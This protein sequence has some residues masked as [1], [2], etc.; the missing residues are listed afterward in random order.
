MLYWY[1]QFFYQLK[2]FYLQSLVYKNTVNIPKKRDCVLKQ[3]RRE[4]NHDYVFLS[5][6][7]DNSERFPLQVICLMKEELLQY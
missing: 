3:P 7:L 2:F 4:K 6:R 1:T 5:S